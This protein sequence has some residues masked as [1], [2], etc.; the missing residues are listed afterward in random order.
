VEAVE[1]I[2]SDLSLGPSMVSTPPNINVSVKGLR[3]PSVSTSLRVYVPCVRIKLASDMCFIWR[4]CEA[5]ATDRKASGSSY[6]PKPLGH[7]M[8]QSLWVILCPKASGSSVS[9]IRVLCRSIESNILLFG[10]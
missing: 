10:A 3:M 1:G 7:P 5:Q 4:G 6:V 2:L 8:S 9:M